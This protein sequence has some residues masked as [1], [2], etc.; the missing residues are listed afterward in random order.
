MKGR[1]RK[2]FYC[3]LICNHHQRHHHQEADDMNY[4]S[5]G[6]GGGQQNPRTTF[7][8]GNIKNRT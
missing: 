6:G 2:N 3:D 1:F 8:I 4:L 5:I 7:Y